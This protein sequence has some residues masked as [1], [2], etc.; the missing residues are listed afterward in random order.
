M[1]NGK[2]ETIK[3]VTVTGNLEAAMHKSLVTLLNNNNFIFSLDLYE[4]LQI[5]LP[6]FSFAVL[7]LYVSER[8][9]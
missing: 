5:S 2:K 8:T 7:I 1:R 3:Y 9:I 6:L 4:M